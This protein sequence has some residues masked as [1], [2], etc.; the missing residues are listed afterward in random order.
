[1]SGLSLSS[2][3]SVPCVVG[4]PKP[5]GNESCG[6]VSE[7]VGILGMYYVQINELNAYS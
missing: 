5:G 1:M 3:F 4:P 7:N 2:H 6:K